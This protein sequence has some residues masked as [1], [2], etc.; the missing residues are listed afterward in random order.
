MNYTKLLL[1]PL[2]CAPIFG[3]A[4]TQEIAE[5]QR[6]NPNVIFIESSDLTPEFEQQLASLNQK[7]IVYTNEI[8]VEDLAIYTAKSAEDSFIGQ[9]KNGGELQQIK[10]WLGQNP[11]IQIISRSD[12]DSA[13]EDKQTFLLNNNALVLIGEKLTQ[14]DI[15]NYE[16][17][18]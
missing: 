9:T 2:F 8:S 3:Y 14:T 5:W 12:F 13:S 10:D 18:H 1:F 11:S 4:Q 7:Y 6:I 15:E 17:N 16:A